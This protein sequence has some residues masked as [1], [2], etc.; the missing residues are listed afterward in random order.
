MSEW[1]TFTGAPEQFLALSGARHGVIVKGMIEPVPMADLQEL[2]AYFRKHGTFE[3]LI[4][5]SHPLADMICQQARTGQEVWVLEPI[6]VSNPKPDIDFSIH[7]TYSN[8]GQ[9]VV[10]KDGYWLEY[11]TDTPN[12]YIPGAQYSFTR[13]GVY[14]AN[15]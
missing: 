4:C 10:R 6:V 1:Q 2:T 8:K 12:W 14:H 11:T 3:F 7:E 9:V 15:K 5:S 13:D